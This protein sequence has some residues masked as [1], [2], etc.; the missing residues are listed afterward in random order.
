MH[1]N[2]EL[3]LLTAALLRCCVS[4]YA[5]TNEMNNNKQCDGTWGLAVISK[6][7]PKEIVV[8]CSG[9][10]MVIGL[11]QGHIYVASEASHLLRVTLSTSS[12]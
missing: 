3:R 1:N 7:Q 4:C 10:P 5:A 12:T 2:N 6:D 8:A 9:S 11:G